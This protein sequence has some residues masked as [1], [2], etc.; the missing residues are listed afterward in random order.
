MHLPGGLKNEPCIYVL[1]VFLF[2][3]FLRNNY[4]ILLIHILNPLLP[5]LQN[6]LCIETYELNYKDMEPTNNKE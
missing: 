6:T 4:N 1:Q 3:L 5:R 2:F